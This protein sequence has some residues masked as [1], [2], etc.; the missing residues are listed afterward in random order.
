MLIDKLREY[1]NTDAYPFHMPG[2][3]RVKGAYSFSNLYDVDI[4][5]IDGFDNLHH[6]EGILKEAMDKAAEIYHADRS[7][8]LVNGS[9]C[10]ILS[11]ICACTKPGDKILLARNSHK[12]S[13]HGCEI[14]SLKPVYIWPEKVENF[15]VNGC[16]NP[17]KVAEYLEDVDIRAVMITS[18][19]YE[20]VV[21]DI[22]AIADV[23]HAHGIPLIVDEA[24]GA[25]F[26][27]SQ[28]FPLSAVDLGADIV[29]QSLH[30]TLPSLTQT[31]ILHLNRGFVDEKKLEHYLTVF[32]SSS[33]SYIFMS[34]IE[35]CIEYMNSDGRVEMENYVK[36]LDSFYE[37]LQGLSKIRF[38]NKKDLMERNKD[39]V[40]S[41]DMS[42][43]VLFPETISGTELASYIREKYHIEPEM[44]C[45]AYC[46]YMTSVMDTLEG[47]ERLTKAI[48][49]TDSYM[50]SGMQIKSDAN[51]FSDKNIPKVG[52]IS[53]GFITLY[54][55]GIPL[56]AP[57][58]IITDE[59]VGQIVDSLALGLTVEGI[60][61]K[62][63]I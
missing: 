49:E 20:G 62:K 23:C 10:G 55:P 26:T 36:R 56:A 50:E 27:Y 60:E 3:K 43:V 32:Q 59:I 47:F 33:P 63:D 57:G 17:Q 41:W 37:C 31:A 19:T 12:S 13:Y 44:S 8:F 46:L 54:P 53:E 14:H 35:N 30:K 29:I 38:L 9:T 15:P 16:I 51:I 1:S 34:S 24:H 21:S 4:T 5:E 61:L 6:A 40:F 39:S 48:R 42:K 18:P 22:K 11:G 2:H 28:N 25:H 45:K 7:F 58:E 52:D